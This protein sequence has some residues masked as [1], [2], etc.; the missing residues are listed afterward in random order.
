LRLPYQFT[1]LLGVYTLVQIVTF[2]NRR[3]Y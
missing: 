1:V 2:W 3:D